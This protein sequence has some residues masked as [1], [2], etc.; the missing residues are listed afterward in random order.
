MRNLFSLILLFFTVYSSVSP[1]PIGL[2]A[3]RE[4]ALSFKNS[5][6]SKMKKTKSTMSSIKDVEYDFNGKAEAFF[7]FN[8]N[9]TDGFAIIGNDNNENNVLAYADNGSFRTD[10]M[11][12]SVKTLLQS[13]IEEA[14]IS[15][16]QSYSLANTASEREVIVQPLLGNIVYSQEYPYNIKCP[17]YYG[18]ENS[19]SGCVATVMTQIMKYYE[20]PT[21]PTGSVSY[22]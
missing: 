8:F 7:I 9:N 21:N 16:L 5:K 18:N 4:R 17:V 11:P 3:A 22:T 10:K 19:L 20:Y 2:D 1:E 13:Y 15:S 14:T 12:T 6:K